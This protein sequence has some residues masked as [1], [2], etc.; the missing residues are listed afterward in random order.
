VSIFNQ[1]GELKARWGGGRN[2][3][4]PGDFFAPHGIWVDSR[5]DIYVGEVTMSAGGN[6]G[7]VSPDC[8]PL[9]KFVLVDHT[10]RVKRPSR[11]A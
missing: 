8:H 6:R 3:C 2:P 1:R 4:S 10:L 7:L 5:G 9:Q 11:E